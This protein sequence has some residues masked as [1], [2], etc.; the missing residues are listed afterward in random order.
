[1][2]KKFD[3]AETTSFPETPLPSSELWKS[4]ASATK[5]EIKAY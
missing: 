2:A 5:R 3:L 4:E 1:M